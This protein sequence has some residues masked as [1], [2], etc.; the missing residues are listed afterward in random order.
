MVVAQPLCGI[1]VNPTKENQSYPA[2][3]MS[4]GPGLNEE[5]FSRVDVE[6]R[7][8]VLSCDPDQQRQQCG[9]MRRTFVRCRLNWDLLESN[10]LSEQWSLGIIRI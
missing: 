1:P 10:H 2:L 6:S 9:N 8:S 3:F 5:E 7:K 4:W